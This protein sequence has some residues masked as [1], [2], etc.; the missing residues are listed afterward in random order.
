MTKRI[1]V[2]LAR[3]VVTAY[4]GD[5]AVK[6]FDCVCGRGGLTVPGEFRISRKIQDYRS[7]KYDA[8]MPFSLFFSDD[9]KAFHGSPWAVVRGYLQWLNI[10]DWGSHGCV[11][12]DNS[13]AQWLYA[14][15]P[16][17]TAVRI[18]SG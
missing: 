8:P 17:G 10:A 5:K 13:D 4:E 18:Y 9:G 6:V 11:G 16:V 3:N 2:N 7:R 1:E 15:S 14:W 12:L